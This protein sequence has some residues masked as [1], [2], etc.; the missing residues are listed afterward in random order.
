MHTVCVSTGLTM[1]PSSRSHQQKTI[2]LLSCLNFLSSHF[3]LSN[4]ARHRRLK[5]VSAV[6]LWCCLLFLCFIILCACVD[7]NVQ[8]GGKPECV[9]V[10]VWVCVC[11]YIYLFCAVY[12]HFLFTQSLVF[13]LLF[14]FAL[15]PC[16][17]SLMFLFVFLFCRLLGVRRT[18]LR[19]MGSFR[20]NV[21]NGF[22]PQPMRYFIGSI[23]SY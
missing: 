23:Y 2:E 5:N 13:I 3:N 14:L 20:C 16:S 9:C 22:D 11:G 21:L 19:H 12:F 8:E 7:R 15:F 18:I 6:S 1:H 17:V 10:C 4:L